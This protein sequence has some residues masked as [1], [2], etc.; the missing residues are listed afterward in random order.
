M[1]I[2]SLQFGALR[3]G[4]ANAIAFKADGS[5][6]DTTMS[7]NLKGIADGVLGASID[8]FVKRHKDDAWH[9][10]QDVELYPFAET[11]LGSVQYSVYP[12]VNGKDLTPLEHRKAAVI[13]DWL[14]EDSFLTEMA[15]NAAKEG[16]GEKVG[17][18]PFDGTH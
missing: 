6:E 9:Q 16:R 11:K 13:S 3:R 5:G 2:P 1:S 17:F 8:A 18:D 12:R 10:G 4:A 14:V 7:N 15:Q